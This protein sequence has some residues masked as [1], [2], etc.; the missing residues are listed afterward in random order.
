MKKTTVVRPVRMV[1]PHWRGG[2]IDAAVAATPAAF[3]RKD[4][5][6]ILS[7][8]YKFSC[9]CALDLALPCLDFVPLEPDPTAVSIVRNLVDV[10]A[11]GLRRS[12]QQQ[13]DIVHCENVLRGQQGK[14]L[15]LVKSV[16]QFSVHDKMQGN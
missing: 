4:F 6:F 1:S 9:W 11:D 13:R 10:V 8:V 12:P 14:G 5:L 3:R 15:Y 16:F 7:N 2:R